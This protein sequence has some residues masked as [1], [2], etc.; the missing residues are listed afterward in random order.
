MP[1][2]N[3]GLI[4]LKRKSPPKRPKGSFAMKRSYLQFP[5]KPRPTKTIINNIPVNA[6]SK[7]IEQYEKHLR[8]MTNTKFLNPSETSFHNNV[9]RN[10]KNYR[11]LMKKPNFK[12]SNSQVE[13]IV[14]R[15]RKKSN[16]R[17]AA[18]PLHTSRT[19]LKTR[20]LIA[21]KKGKQSVVNKNKHI[22][23][24]YNRS[25]APVSN[26]TVRINK[27]A[28]N[29]NK[30]NTNSNRSNINNGNRSNNNV[31]VRR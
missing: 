24:K 13:S 29:N 8:L 4:A 25:A 18:V 17:A 10:I 31:S 19:A 22:L 3:N 2:Q 30:S 20:A 9:V 27:N 15:M 1:T 16:K 11:N 21:S 6:S 12:P 7:N 5:K 26:K 28:F 14:M 23:I